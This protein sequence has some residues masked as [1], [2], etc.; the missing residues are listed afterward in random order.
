MDTILNKTNFIVEAA[1]GNYGGINEINKLVEDPAVET[2]D[3]KSYM[4]YCEKA[5]GDNVKNVD[6]WRRFEQMKHIAK[7]KGLEKIMFRK[8]VHTFTKFTEKYQDG[9]SIDFIKVTT[10]YGSFAIS[11]GRIIKEY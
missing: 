5:P 8:D 7:T 6:C 3:I 11:A 1:S 9:E 2:A 4:R 10:D